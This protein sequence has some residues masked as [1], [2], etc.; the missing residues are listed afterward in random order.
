MQQRRR[1]RGRDPHRGGSTTETAT[2]TE[3]AAAATETATATE[4]PTEAEANAVTIGASEF[5]FDLSNA[6]FVPGTN[7][8]TM[9]N[10]GEQVHHL[11]FVGLTEGTTMED[12]TAGLQAFEEGGPFPE[13][14][15]LTGGVGQIGPGASAGTVA[16]LQAGTY[17]LLCLVPDPADG[18]PHFA[19]GMAA[20]IEVAGDENTAAVPEAN[21]EVTAVDYGFEAPDSVAA[22]DV[23]L[24]LSNNGG[25]PHEANLLQLAE[26]A[27]V[28]DAVAFFTSEAP[29]A[30][31]PPFTNVGGAQGIFP[32]DSTVA[33]VNLAAGNYALICFIP[34][35][36]GAPHFVLGMTKEFAAE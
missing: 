14:A 10:T 33:T 4:A 20:L 21:F 22:G 30:G 9:N 17:A 1:R 26:G 5:A 11:Q 27:T 25:E 28:E 35:A 29:P 2:A 19:K 7:A 13:F 6:N 24:K 34:N 8:I 3:T 12:L 16:E 23:V 36:E 18:V 32:G 31:P 15:T